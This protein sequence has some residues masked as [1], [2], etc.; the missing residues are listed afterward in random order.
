MKKNPNLSI[1][2]SFF[3]LCLIFLIGCGRPSDPQAAFVEEFHLALIS[4]NE[5]KLQELC[6]TTEQAIKLINLENE[7]EEW[8]D[9]NRKKA[10]KFDEWRNR[11]LSEM[12]SEIY[13]PLFGVNW[14]NVKTVDYKFIENEIVKKRFNF[15]YAATDGKKDFKIR[16]I[17]V[18]LDGNF[19]ARFNS[20]GGPAVSLEN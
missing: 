14:K 17:L 20:V 10:K 2:S 4:K 9:R 1:K 8:K 18:F 19:Y 16:V 11:F 12:E 7:S 15:L 6:L 3:F 13:S 5:K